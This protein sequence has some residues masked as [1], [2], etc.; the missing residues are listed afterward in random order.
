M[1]GHATRHLICVAGCWILLAVMLQ[2][3][4]AVPLAP[5]PK[6]ASVGA[7]LLP[8][9]RLGEPSRRT[10]V[11]VFADADGHERHFRGVN[12]VVKGPPWHPSV[13]AF[14]FQTSMVEQDFALLQ[15]AGVTVVRLGILWAGVE[16]VR[17]QYNY[18]YI[19]TLRGVAQKASSYGIYTLLDMHQDV[20]SEK[21]CGEGMPP[22]AVQPS[23]SLHF[24]EPIG[25][26]FLTPDTGSGFPTRTDCAR[27]PWSS[28][29]VSEA[30][31]TAWQALFSNKDGLLD[32]WGA[33]WHTVVSVFKGDTH[34]LGIEAINEPFAGDVL[35][36]P[37]LLEPVLA[38][39]VNLERA[40]ASVA[41]QVWDADPSRLFFFAPVTW[42]NL[43][44]GFQSAP[45]GE[46]NANRSVLVF[47]HYERPWG[48]QF[49]HSSV[50]HTERY[51]KD[52][53]RLGTGLMLTEIAEVFNLT[54]TPAHSLAISRCLRWRRAKRLPVFLPWTDF[55]LC[56]SHFSWGLQHCGDSP[57]SWESWDAITGAAEK[58][59]TSW[60][61]WEFKRFSK[62][63]PYPLAESQWNE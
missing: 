53:A 7:G 44:S 30:S 34:V 35:H 39:R 58:H 54:L 26:A 22:W 50:K 15:A 31:S 19:N 56:L 14:D 2:A 59:L 36:D 47:H 10:G 1:C 48:P 8:A 41:R 55:G 23:G 42:A 32:A 3:A 38:D 49:K 25:R 40:Y 46:A 28:Y 43:G 33:M 57:E 9:I 27:H 63:P 20:M 6:P 12:A 61:S 52:A 45:A 18:T 62:G 24:P 4:H 21:F 5:G 13:G 60:V 51:V 16:P 11:R 29:Y 37:L 17:G